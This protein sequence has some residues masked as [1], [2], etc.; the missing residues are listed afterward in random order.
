MQ[1]QTESIAAL[2]VPPVRSNFVQKNASLPRLNA[3]KRTRQKSVEN[4][5]EHKHSEKNT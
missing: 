5:I 4:Y 1:T 2:D 3:H